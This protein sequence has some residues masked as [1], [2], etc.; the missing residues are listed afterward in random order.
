MTAPLE[1]EPRALRRER[2][3]LL[4]QVMRYAEVPLFVLS[5]LWLVLLV[6]EF[7][8]GLGP[9]LTRASYVI[10]AIFALQFLLEFVI[11]PSR[12]V[13]LRKQ[14]LTLLALLVPALRLFRVAR[15]ARLVQGARAARGVR[16]L[17]VVTTANRGMRALAKS[18]SRRGAGYVASLTVVVLLASAAGMLGFERDEPGT[19]ITSYGT[20][21]WWTAMVL[22]TMGSDYWPRSPEGRLL[23]LGLSLYAFGA[24]GYLTAALA[25]FFVDREQRDA[26]HET[27]ASIDARLARIEALLDH[28]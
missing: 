11:A 17:R 25:S 7:T 23:C 13:F 9:V 6:V 26:Q 18:M 4:A 1:P 20:A 2:W 27:P 5:A 12:A 21:L 10:W 16:L 28:K 24:F 3:R 15:V 19:P 14:W 8:R 22:T